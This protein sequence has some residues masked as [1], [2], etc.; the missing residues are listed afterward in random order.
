MSRYQHA[1]PV[2]TSPLADDLVSAP[3]GLVTMIPA[4]SFMH[5]KVWWEVFVID[6]EFKK[7]IF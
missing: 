2:P 5:K 7:K 3:S 4:I 6:V 1:N